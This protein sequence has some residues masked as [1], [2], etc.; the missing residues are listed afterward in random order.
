MQMKL[1]PYLFLFHI[2]FVNGQD[3]YFDHYQVED[4]LSHNTVTSSVQD[5]KG[6]LWFGTKNGLN[7]FDGYTFRLFQREEGHTKTLQSNYILSLQEH[8]GKLWVGT[9]NG[10]YIYN[11]QDE[12]FSLIET[13]KESQ[14][15]DIEGDNNGNLW[16]RGNGSLGRYHIKEQTCYWYPS[17][18]FFNASDVI[19]TSEG[20]WASSHTHMYKYNSSTDS[21]EPYELSPEPIKDKPFAIN[22]TF[23][24]DERTILIGTPNHGV[25]MF[26]LI[27]KETKEADFLGS[28]RQHVRDFALRGN[29]L[30]VASESGIHIYNRNTQQYS[31]PKKNYDDPYALSDNAVYT[32]TVDNEGGVWAGTYFGGINYQPKQY[33]PFK[34]YFPKSSENSLNGNAIRE[35]CEDD[36]G[37]IWIGTEDG[38]LNKYDPNSQVFSNFTSK[39]KDSEGIL[40]H[41]NIHA[42][43]PYDGKLYIGM[44]ENGIDVLDI[45]T[46]KKIAHYGR[47]SG[48]TSD[49]V[50]AIYEDKNEELYFI[51]T[52][53]M[54][55]FDKQ[56]NSFKP[57]ENLPDHQG[58]TCFLED[59]E[60]KQWA[61]TYFGGLFS[62]N[63]KSQENNTYS[64]DIDNPKS[65]SNNHINYLFQD[66]KNNI[67]VCTEDG[68]N[69]YNPENDSF[70]RYGM[71]DGFPANVF[72]AIL[73]D[74]FG[75]L[76]ITTSKG[77]V[78]FNSVTKDI[79][80]YTKADGLQ[81]DNFNYMSAHK[82][83]DGTLFF[84]SVNGMISFNPEKF[85]KNTYKAPIYITGIQ[86]NNEDVYVD[87]ENS[88]LIESVTSLEKI[89]L[90]P[91]QSSFSLEFAALS[92]TA[93]E[94]TEYWYKMEGLDTEWV[95]LQKN[96][97]AYFTELA[98]GTYN[99][100]V[101][102]MNSSG[103]W[104]K[105]TAGL[106][107]K[108]LP[109]F[110]KSHWAYLS[111]TGLLLLL[112]FF[113]F[114]TYHQRIKLK[115]TRKIRLLNNRKEKE[116]YEAKIEF[117]TNISHEIRTPLTLIKS[118]LEKVL[119]TSG[120]L[121]GV[122][123]NLN[124]VKRNANRLLD[125]VNQL[126]DFRKTEIERVDL[127]FLR[128]NVTKLLQNTATRFSEAIRDKEIDFRLNIEKDD[129]YASVD[130]EALKKILSNLFGNAI[131]YAESK[132]VVLL[133]EENAHF[134]MVIQNDGNLIPSHLR[135]KIFEPF[136][137]LSGLENETGTGI[138]LALARSLT[139]MHNGTLHI[140]PT[141]RE[142]NSF[143]LSL[144][145]KQEKEF[146][147]KP[148]REED[149]LEEGLNDQPVAQSN[150][151]TIL[152]VE[153]SIEL[154]DFIARELREDY[155]VLKAT[156][157]EKA[158]KILQEEKVQLIISDVMMPG[159][160]G[161]DLCKKIKTNL[162]TSHI[163]VILL[164]SKSAMS[165]KMEGLESGAEAYIEKPF[166]VKHLKVHIANLIENRRHVMD[167]YASSPLAHIRSIANTK[168]DDNFIKKLDNVII[169]HMADADL[170]VETLAEIMHM[171]RSTLY[172][173]IKDISNLSPN[174]LINIA[175]LKKSAELL[176]TGNYRVFEVAEIVGYNSPT[177]FG[178][179]FQKQFEMSPTEYMNSKD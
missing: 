21:F 23:F 159:I 169:E 119:R 179:N 5:G 42:L 26:D 67:W 136:Y 53:G 24:L 131:K 116:I 110:Y 109:P 120:H 68:L 94:N 122:K 66:S 22:E 152:V 129:V 56:S 121:P 33:T 16:F 65:V 1:I 93:P 80:V 59:N 150:E 38:G 70:K 155:Y 118:P 90:K 171:S 105:E 84:G 2:A 145:L 27:T 30:W 15:W 92:F 141:D 127:T 160:N 161:F 100:K 19:N 75:I 20:V 73:E 153:D 115:N 95:Y 107:I 46:N 147:L 106:Q 135:E 48:L 173:K 178:R 51:T 40:A 72:Y 50:Y 88:P 28:E 85:I 82:R 132:I 25:L 78:A 142:M 154:I 18:E 157:A 133:K 39:E 32:L 114:R 139:E 170:N 69:L 58:Y 117:F 144:P 166:S 176:K 13:T 63:P 96:H 44:F 57:Y 149:K 123:D 168:T 146:I 175:R 47:E 3:Y 43:Y 125:L 124:I 37:N 31:N 113:G 128:T 91:S 11:D 10:L 102:S 6:F 64:F 164:T 71:Q 103:V 83:E 41:Y 74:D 134:K 130:P 14:I 81:S 138:G 55:I 112:I 49:F 54:K 77:L 99:F 8:A 174:E 140:D 9:D 126:L 172:R 61:G 62:Y 34:K 148:N 108:V 156:D 79:K 137:R 143:I 89:T 7:R 177:S 162:E 111:Y 86:I 97:K 167:H 60:G 17:N 36:N 52:S 98:P 158:L 104:G 29:E 87:Q 4:G 76:W 45:D 101:R 151:N 163:P 35:I 165:S 12:S